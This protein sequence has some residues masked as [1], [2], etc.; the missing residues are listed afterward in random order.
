MTLVGDFKC[1]EVKWEL[2]EGEGGD[3]TWGNRLLNLTM[4]N[5]MMQWVTEKTRYRGEDEP[6]RLDLVFTKGTD[7]AKEIIYKCPIGKSSHVI[8]E[9]VTRG[10]NAREKDESHKRRRRNYA[11]A[12]FNELK[13]YF[14]KTDWKVLQELE[15]VQQKYDA[16]LEIYEQG[17]KKHVPLYT[18][19]EKGKK[20]WFN[21]MCYKAKRKG[22]KHGRN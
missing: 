6:S 16:F 9:I 4:N 11:K 8:L 3:H 2:F 12:N 19:K 22:I 5:M 20:E 15:D 13:E 21:V 10:D 18:V 7:L 1:S 14:E 17:V